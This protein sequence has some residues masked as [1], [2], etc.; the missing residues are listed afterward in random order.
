MFVTFFE[1]WSIP[2]GPWYLWVLILFNTAAV[3]L[4]LILAVMGFKR[5]TLRYS[6][7]S[8][9]LQG[10]LFQWMG[11]LFAVMALVLLAEREKVPALS[12]STETPKSI[13]SPE[14]PE[15]P[16]TPEKISK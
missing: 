11:Q 1:Y 14:F 16:D 9:A 10:L 12:P 8:L 5:N 4:T 3:L 7:C 13:D 6:L 15:F 2:F